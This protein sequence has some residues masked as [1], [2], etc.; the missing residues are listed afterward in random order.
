[1]GATDDVL[2][3]L[4]ARVGEALPDLRVVLETGNVQ[5]NL[6]RV[7]DGEL[8]AALVWHADAIVGTRA[9]E[10]TLVPLYAT[11]AHGHSLAV[12]A[13]DGRR[14]DLRDLRDFPVVLLSEEIDPIIHRTVL[15]WCASA[16]FEPEIVHHDSVHTVLAAVASNHRLWT[17]MP[18]WPDRRLVQVPFAQDEVAGSIRLITRTTH[19]SPA[20]RSFVRAVE[21]LALDL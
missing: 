21:A 6:R 14:V 18:D 7:R 11:V 16:G 15:D 5:D 13:G 2:S 19:A 3:R 20:T 10:I 1:M 4:L 12:S 8:D 9:L 17:L